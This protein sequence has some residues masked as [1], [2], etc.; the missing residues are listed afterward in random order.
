MLCSKSISPFVLLHI[1]APDG[2]LANLITLLTRLRLLMIRTFQLRAPAI[3]SDYWRAV[4]DGGE[5]GYLE[6]HR[7]AGLKTLGKL[8]AVHRKAV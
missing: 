1:V 2:L 8:V 3:T 6:K 7:E 4:G 5:C